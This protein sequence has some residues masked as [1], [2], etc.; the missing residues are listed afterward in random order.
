MLPNHSIKP[1]QL[2][3]LPQYL[4]EVPNRPS[5]FIGRDGEIQKIRTKLNANTKPVNANLKPVI[6]TGVGGIG[7]TTLA[8]QYLHTYK[9]E[10][11]HII[12]VNCTDDTRIKEAVVHD[13]PHDI[14]QL[15]EKAD[16]TEG[17]FKQI[18]EKLQALSG[19]NL[20]VLDSINDVKD[21]KRTVHLLRQWKIQGK[22]WHILITS[23]TRLSRFE[24]Y[25]VEGLP[26]VEAKKLFHKYCQQPKEDN[27]L[28]DLLKNIGRHTLTIE[29][30]AKSLNRGYTISMAQLLTE[31]K[32]RGLSEI[33]CNECVYTHYND[34]KAPVCIKD[35]LSNMYKKMFTDET[36]PKVLQLLVC[37][38]VLPPLS[39]A[40]TE[41]QKLLQVSP[42]AR[43]NFK[44]HLDDL[45]HQGWLQYKK[46]KYTMHLI[47]QEMIRTYLPPTTQNCNTL[48]YFLLEIF[49]D[50]RFCSFKTIHKYV[51]HLRS[52]IKH[53]NEKNVLHS[54]LMNKLAE[55]ELREGNYEEALEIQEKTLS[56]RKQL[57][58][59]KEL[60]KIDLSDDYYFLSWIYFHKNSFDEAQHYLQDS[61]AIR[62][63]S[64]EKKH[65]KLLDCYHL[66][67]SIYQ[68]KGELQIA[69]AYQEKILTLLHST[70]EQLSIAFCYNTLA[71]INGDLGL[72]EKAITLQETAISIMQKTTNHYYLGLFFQNLSYFFK[73]VGNY[74]KALIFNQKASSI[75]TKILKPKH[76]QLAVIHRHLATIQLH[77][78][79]AKQAL[80]IQAQSIQI[81]LEQFEKTH[82]RIAYSYG[83]LSQIHLALADF[84]QALAYQEKCLAI[85]QKH[86]HHKHASI[87]Y[88]YTAFASIYLAQKDF[89]QAQQ[90]IV[91]ALS[92][93][94]IQI[95]KHPS[96][97]QHPDF[98]KALNLKIELSNR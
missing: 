53:I 34:F 41:L 81:E 69:K 57:W 77:L 89:T 88:S 96:F 37:F 60:S 3:E 18:I 93:Y 14:L 12:W 83:N 28:L 2:P 35:I 54:K 22:N 36:N 50:I 29:L 97:E 98:Q 80:A 40:K 86:F 71:S 49:K 73:K 61:L 76:P 21:I 42:D 20:F 82:L 24:L 39:F 48:I 84:K 19:T 51:P 46:E 67:S 74:H 8:Q 63:D 16:S 47:I 5:V 6:L 66:L 44:K 92:I 26:L 68:K 10:Y 75:L 56:I 79:N 55:I 1:N 59:K 7:K 30:L 91:D 13:I 23:R 38:A 70:N 11:A 65:S 17:Q 58:A 78:G 94:K 4:T 9:A 87:A 85:K 72:F 45:I 33:S 27:Y 52:I 95:A 25:D 31:V 64:L 32:Q 62:L 90:Y 43:T 15:D